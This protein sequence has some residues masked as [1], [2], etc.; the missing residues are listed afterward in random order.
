MASHWHTQQEVAVCRH[1]SASYLCITCRAL[2]QHQNQHPVIYAKTCQG[3]VHL[4]CGGHS[5][6]AYLLRVLMHAAGRNRAHRTL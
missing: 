5:S 3:K 4:D 2:M 1:A 6:A